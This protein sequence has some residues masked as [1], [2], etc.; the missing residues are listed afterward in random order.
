MWLNFQSDIIV[1]SGCVARITTGAAVPQGAD[2]VVQVEDTE[3]IESSDDVRM[4]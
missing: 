4:S 1:T 2:S 3:L